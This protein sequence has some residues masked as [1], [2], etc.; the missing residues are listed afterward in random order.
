MEDQRV[1][2]LADSFRKATSEGLTIEGI[3]L[4]VF[5]FSFIALALTLGNY[6]KKVLSIKRQ[7]AHFIKTV[8]DLGLKEKE[9]EILWEYSKKLDRDPY[10]SLEVKATFEKVIDE[11]IKEN[12]NFDE[13]MIRDMRR[14]LGFD[15]I[16]PFMPLV[17][18]KDIEIFQNGT[19]LFEGKS[20]PVALT[21]KD[22]LYMYWSILEGNPTV[23]EGQTVKITFLRQ[24]DAVYVFEGEI[25][26]T[27]ID[28]GRKVI[29]I[30][31]TFNLVRN[32]RRK[33]I[34]IKAELP[35]NIKLIDE[36][37]N[38]VSFEALTENIS[39][40]GFKFCLSKADEEFVQ[41]LSINQEIETYIKISEETINVK[42]I[43]RNIQNRDS[44]ICF[45][46]EFKEIDK[47][48]EAFLGQF[49]QD[50][51]MELMKKYKQMQKG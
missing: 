38:I 20:Y 28:M 50:K 22:E 45:G 3:L 41:K 1:N 42:G 48:D 27:F 2:I 7:K 33:D 25:I 23:K 12:P 51:Q 19:L 44:K 31:H 4:V 10:L 47:K 46:V 49:I 17:S 43:I 9:G 16:P 18:T 36:N 21:D 29:K 26:E 15:S 37:G 30:P 24:E 8:V 35:V 11:Y 14:A 5:I 40:S 34:R 39:T 13:N 6:I 32:Q